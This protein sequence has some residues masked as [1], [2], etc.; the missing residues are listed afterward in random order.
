MTAKEPKLDT[1]KR[2]RYFK[3]NKHRGGMNI[4]GDH[5]SVTS[6]TPLSSFWVASRS[7]PHKMK[8]MG[9]IGSFRVFRWMIWMPND[10]PK[11]GYHI[12]TKY[13]QLNGD[14]TNKN[15]YLSTDL[16]MWSTL[17]SMI[18][19][20]CFQGYVYHSPFTQRLFGIA[21][22]SNPTNCQGVR[23]TKHGDMW[24]DA[25]MYVVCIYIYNMY[26]KTVA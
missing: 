5:L 17:A 1:T 10:Q 18:S 16:C 7:V 2:N 9:M 4:S 21:I 11:F 12:I 15:W 22:W 3:T 23:T 13:N 20:L 26:I 19:H 8:D 25:Y 24:K 6:L 14:K